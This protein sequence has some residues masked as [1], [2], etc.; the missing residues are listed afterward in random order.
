[1]VTKREKRKTDMANSKRSVAKL[2]T[3]KE[4]TDNGQSIK[5]EQA[6]AA[7]ATIT[8]NIAATNISIGDIDN[9]IIIDEE[10][11]PEEPSALV[12]DLFSLKNGSTVNKNRTLFK[13]FNS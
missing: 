3:V 7:I 9:E 5:N 6:S 13:F 4:E 10:R 8:A 1:M 12:G 11:T 2:E